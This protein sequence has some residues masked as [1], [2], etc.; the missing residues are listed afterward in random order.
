MCE[1][2]RH[3]GLIVLDT[4]WTQVDHLIMD[5]TADQQGHGP[6]DDGDTTWMVEHRLAAVLEVLNVAL[7]PK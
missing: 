3:V 2:S 5:L 4:S 6:A 1:V 7:W